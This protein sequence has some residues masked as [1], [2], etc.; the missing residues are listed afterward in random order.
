MSKLSNLEKLSI[1]HAFGDAVKKAEKQVREEVDWQMR[2]DFTDS[3]VDRKRLTVNGQNV[4]TIS[5]R[6]SKGE[7]GK[8]PQMGNAKEFVR[9]L[10]ESD[11]GQ[12]TLERMVTAKPDWC[13]AEAMEDGEVPDGVEFVERDIKPA[14][15]G[16]TLRVQLPKVIEALGPQLGATAAALLNG[17]VE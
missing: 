17:E 13:I 11:G 2:E 15:V 10:R 5:V 6:M 7:S 16:T 1:I 4:G 8:F 14:Y 9:W 3:G 12:D